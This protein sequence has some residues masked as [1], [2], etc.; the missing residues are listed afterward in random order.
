M[1]I[2]IVIPDRSGLLG[3]PVGAFASLEK[4]EVAAD[5][6]FRRTHQ[7][8]TTPEVFTTGG[9]TKTMRRTYITEKGFDNTKY[10]IICV[11]VE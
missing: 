5:L 9:D 2:F 6:D 8:G 1:N 3:F 10:C 7:G 4:A 11:P